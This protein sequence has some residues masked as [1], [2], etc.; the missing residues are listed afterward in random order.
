MIIASFACVSLLLLQSGEAIDASEPFVIN[1]IPSTET[2]TDVDNALSV[3]HAV[4]A[5]NRARA[6]EDDASRVTL[7]LDLEREHIAHLLKRA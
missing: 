3:V 1:L 2:N 5:R 7:L 4:S 6:D